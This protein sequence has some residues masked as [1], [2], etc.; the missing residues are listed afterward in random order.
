MNNAMVL[1]SRGRPRIYP[2]SVFF[3]IHKLQA[4][5][6]VL[7]LLHVYRAILAVRWSD[8]RDAC[9]IAIVCPDT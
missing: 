6:T 7:Y 3:C 5:L 4:D 2:A 1:A 8:A 9:E